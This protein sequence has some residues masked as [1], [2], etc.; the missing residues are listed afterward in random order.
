M[1][2]PALRKKVIRQIVE[3]QTQGLG[4]TEEAALQDAPELHQSACEQFGTWDT[5]LQYAGIRLCC[6]SSRRNYSKEQVIQKI[7]EYCR[8]RLKPTATR[9]R[10]DDYR[11]QEAAREHFGGWRQALLAAGLNVDLAGFGAAKPPRLSNDQLLDRLR[12]WGEEHSLQWRDICLENRVLA[13]AAR[14][15]FRSWRRALAAATATVQTQPSKT[16]R[17]WDQQSVIEHILHRKQEGKPIGYRAVRADDSSLL[18]AARRQ[19]GTWRHAL[20]ASGVVPQPRRKSS[21]QLP[22]GDAEEGAAISV[23]EA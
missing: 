8:R 6:L 15:R 11:I 10:H 20:A 12:R 21:G 2:V 23:P 9:V 1:I 16:K 22:S 4:L 18:A 17:V 7:R 19:F 13:V 3:R 5:A 14:G